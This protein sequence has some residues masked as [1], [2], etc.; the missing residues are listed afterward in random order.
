MMHTSKSTAARLPEALRPE[1]RP[2]SLSFTCVKTKTSTRFRNAS[3]TFQRSSKTFLLIL[4]VAGIVLADVFFSSAVGLK[5][6]T[7]RNVLFD[8][9]PWGKSFHGNGNILPVWWCH[10]S[11]LKAQNA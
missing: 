6:K 9:M 4:L 5:F 10:N 11:F 7:E 1:T 3:K 8:V 2:I